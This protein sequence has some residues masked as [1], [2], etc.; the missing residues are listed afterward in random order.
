[1]GI[2]MAA[3][4]MPIW[5]LPSPLVPIVAPLAAMLPLLGRLGGLGPPM[6]PGMPGIPGMP[7][8]MLILTGARKREVLD[9]RWEDFDFER[10]SWRIHTT[11]LGRPRHVPLS[12]GAISILQSTPRYHFLRKN[13]RNPRG[14]RFFAFLFPSLKQNQF[15]YFTE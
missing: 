9:A 11:K 10:K 4:G 12:D 1:M 5:P 2:P 3:P 15:L 14:S 8:P 13:F 7:I 6:L